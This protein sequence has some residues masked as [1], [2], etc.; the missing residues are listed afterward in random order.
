[1][2]SPRGAQSGA[3]GNDENDFDGNHS[4]TSGNS[5]YGSDAEG[6]GN[7]LNNGNDHGHG[8]GAPKSRSCVGTQGGGGPGDD[9][10]PG[11]YEVDQESSDDDDYS[12]DDISE[13]GPEV[14]DDLSDGEDEHTARRRRPRRNPK[15]REPR[16]RNCEL[17]TRRWNDEVDGIRKEFQTKEKD[18]KKRIVELEKEN[19]ALRNE[20]RIVW[21]PWA[22]RLGNLFEELCTSDPDGEIATPPGYWEIYYDSCKQGNMSTSRK[23]IHPDL[24]LDDEIHTAADIWSHL[25]QQVPF[26]CYRRWLKNRGLHRVLRDI[27]VPFRCTR[28]HPHRL[29]EDGEYPIFQFE[30][31]PIDIQCLIWK[32]LIPNG[33]M[34]H[35]LSRLDPCHPPRH[36]PPEVVHFPSRFHIGNA[37]CCIAKADEPSKYLD[38]FLVSRRWYYATAHLFYATNT[39]AFSSLGEFGRFCNGIGKARVERLVNVELMWTGALTPRQTRGV[40]LR[41]QP[42]A[43]FMHTSRLR[44][45]A[46]HINESAKF[47]MRRRYEMLEPGHYHIDYASEDYDDNEEELH[48]FGMEV[49]RTDCQPNY[50]KFRAMRTVQGMEF[51]YELRGMNWVRFYDFNAERARQTIRDWSFSQDI[52]NVVRREKTAAMAFK[53]EIENLPTL[54]GLEEYDPKDDIRE[55]VA[56]FY[57]DAL[58]EGVSVGGSETSASSSSSISGPSSF[59]SNSSDSSS[60]ND[61]S[62]GGNSHSSLGSQ[63]ID[64]DRGPEVIDSDTEMGDDS[65]TPNSSDGDDSQ[66]PDT[67]M[68]GTSNG[69]GSLSSSTSDSDHDHGDETSSSGV[70]NGTPIIVIDDDDDGD[71]NSSNQRHRGGHDGGSTDDGLFVR[72]GS[73]TAYTET[74]PITDGEGTNF[75]TDASGVIDLTHLDDDDDDVKEEDSEEDRK[76]N[77][78]KVGELAFPNQPAGSPGTDSSESGPSTPRKSAKRQRGRG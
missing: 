2:S 65:M 78:S 52:C 48:I 34:V 6:T 12:G 69:S 20:K 38:Y 10:D 4:D 59:S 76:P 58:V 21:K 62:S 37:P 31:L 19:E 24:T 53:H 29:L 9:P 28:L 75:G 39:F 16:C 50:R 66:S 3:D 74:D 8:E 60:D 35:C 1:M 61:F 7:D 49:R 27:I 40:S 68:S 54:S 67:D 23:F 73:C 55:L 71:D 57:N 42:L 45:L 14:L 18:L 15:P 17:I 33:E 25:M 44:T 43:W 51:I 63:D 46:V 11:N 72:S 41:K 13:V 30:R 64:M 26:T 47:Y 77:I 32:K 5:D 70:S 36:L 22:P 56:S